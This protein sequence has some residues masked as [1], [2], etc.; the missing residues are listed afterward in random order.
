MPS[1]IDILTNEHGEW[2]FDGERIPAR[3]I[4]YAKS[5][6]GFFTPY[7]GPS[8]FASTLL[9]PISYPILF[10][11]SSCILI[12]IMAAA[13]CVAVASLLFSGWASQRW[14]QNLAS[15][16]LSFAG[17]SATIAFMTAGLGVVCALATVLSVPYTLLSLTTRS[18]AS[19]VSPVVDCFQP[20]DEAVSA[21]PG[22]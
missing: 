9:A 7:S 12:G 2:D 22:L 18:V 15:S 17:S 3:V 5:G 8:D 10:G 14:Q 11:V 6:P 13:T 21:T 20:S 16:A 19:V 4:D 1:I